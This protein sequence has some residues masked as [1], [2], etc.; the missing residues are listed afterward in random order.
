[1]RWFHWQA[2][3]GLA[4]PKVSKIH[5]SL[6][7]GLTKQVF[8]AEASEW[9]QPLPWARQGKAC[10]PSEVSQDPPV[11]ARLGKA[12]IETKRAI[13]HEDIHTSFSHSFKMIYCFLNC[14]LHCLLYHYNYTNM[15]PSDLLSFHFACIFSLPRL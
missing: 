13:C 3:P 15:S 14:L 6:L 10:Y 9:N 11:Q 2:L 5:I 4:Q 12:G 7:R 8:L 1:M